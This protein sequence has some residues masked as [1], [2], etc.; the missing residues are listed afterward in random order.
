MS[1]ELDM[2]RNRPRSLAAHGFTLIELLV[3]IAIIAILISLLLPSLGLA[4]EAAR[5]LTCSANLRGLVQ[6]QQYYINNFKDQFASCSTSGLKI[7][8]TME[9]PLGDR[10]PETP[11]QSY[12]WFSPTLGS[13]MDLSP[14]RGERF[15]QILNRYACA[16][17]RHAN[18][19]W[20]SASESDVADFQRVQSRDGFKQVSYLAPEAF[21]YWPYATAHP[22]SGPAQNRFNGVPFFVQ[23]ADTPVR[24]PISYRPRI[25]RIGQSPSLK[26]MY[27]DGTRF[28]D[29]STQVLDFDWGKSPQF[30][31]SFLSSG[32]IFNDSA[33]FNRSPTAARISARHT[34]LSMNVGYF[35]GHAAMM[36]F[37]QAKRDPTPWYPG[38]STWNP[39]GAATQESIQFMQ[40]RTS[41]VLP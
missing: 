35:D 27:S 40:G 11:V 33:E 2:S 17:A 32:P 23:V 34:G 24:V 39:G 20:N 25:D 16:S 21:N 29:E 41:P 4:R 22:P 30:F 28:Y 31:G 12:D 38:G 18:I 10:T 13:S 6:G 5:G 15:G 19:M 37:S 3:V 9:S 26:C 8:C 14:N 36:K 1:V 7:M